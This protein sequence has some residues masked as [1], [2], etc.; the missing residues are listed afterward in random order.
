MPKVEG[1]GRKVKEGRRKNAGAKKLVENQKYTKDHITKI[2]KGEGKH[3]QRQI[4][5]EK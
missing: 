2:K 1:V 4:Q 3:Q 5:W